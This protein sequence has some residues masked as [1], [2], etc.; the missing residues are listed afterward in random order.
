MWQS[1]LFHLK[2]SKQLSS[3]TQIKHLLINFPTLFHLTHR[4][5]LQEQFSTSICK[6]IKIHNSTEL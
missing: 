5:N 6:N 3:I 2:L 1:D 4:E